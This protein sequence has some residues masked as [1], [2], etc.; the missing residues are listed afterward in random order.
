MSII[1]HNLPIQQKIV[2]VLIY[3][4]GSA[5]ASALEA[6]LTSSTLLFNASKSALAVNFEA[7][8]F[9]AT[10]VLHRNFIFLSPFMRPIPPGTRHGGMTAKFRNKPPLFVASMRPARMSQLLLQR[11]AFGVQCSPF[12]V[13]R[14]AFRAVK[15]KLIPCIFSSHSALIL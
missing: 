14:S 10:V 6:A 7:L 13:Q 3:D 1:V 8:C 15:N 4:Y 5:A 12:S 9:K 11:S 2:Y